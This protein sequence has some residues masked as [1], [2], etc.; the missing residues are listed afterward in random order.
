MAELVEFLMRYA[1]YYPLF[2]A[3][4]WMCGALYYRYHWEKMGGESF[5]DPKPLPSYPA[6]SILLP[7]YNEGD[8]AEE[9]IAYLFKQTYPNFEVIAINDGSKDN[10]GEVLDRLEKQYDKL[11]VVHLATN[12]GKATAMNVGAMMSKNDFFIGIDGDAVLDPHATHWLMSH[13]AFGSPR[14]GAVTGNPR[15][16]NRSSLLGKIQVGEF[17]SIIGMIKRAQRIY[18]RVFTVSG[19][20]V[21]FR[22]TAL[23]R[24][25]YWSTDMITEDIDISWRLQ[26]DH[27]DIRYEPNALCWILMPETLKGLW[28]QRERWAQGGMEVFKRYFPK[29]LSWR[30]R[31]MWLVCVEYLLSVAWAYVVSFIFLLWFIGKFVALPEH[32]VVP[33]L[34]P[35]WNGV[36]LGVTCFMQFAISLAIDSR[37]DKGIGRYYY[38]MIWYPLAY[39]MINAMTVVVA[40]PK[41]LLKKD[42]VKAVWNSPDRGVHQ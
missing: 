14:L 27:W 7:C 35:G 21:A 39:W 12:Q 4:V 37:Y 29:M 25:G 8:L 13:F 17:S 2:M 28:K 33:T 11:R 15:I 32:L 1:Y 16:R 22:R 40:V 42:G 9:T 19:V 38:W 10:T 23:Q 34:V 5:D 41:A 30:K 6:V 3:Y 26:L 18:G 31:R 24:I 20:V 36:I